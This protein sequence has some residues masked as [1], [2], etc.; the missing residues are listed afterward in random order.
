MTIDSWLSAANGDAS[1]LW[2]LSLMSRVAFP[3]SFVWGELA[4][5]AR[6]DTLAA[7]RYFASGPHRSDSILGNPG[8]EFIYGGGGLVNSWPATPG[9]NE[10]ATVRDSNVDTL[11]VGGQLDFATPAV[12]A[13]RELL[14]H[15]RNGHQVVLAGVGHTTSFWSYQPKAST[16]LL[17][18]FLDTGKVDRSLY[19]PAKVDFT[20]EISHTALG[21]GLA[22]TIIALPAIVLLSLLLMWR[23]SRKRGRIG[24][25]ASIALRSVFTLVLGLGGWFAGLLLVL[26]AFPAMALDNMALSVVAIGLPIG[27]GIYLAWLDRSRPGRTI[28]LSAAMAGSLVGAWLGFQA[29]NGLTAVITTII[30]AAIGANLPLIVLDTHDSST[31]EVVKAPQQV[32]TTALQ[33]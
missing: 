13:T 12:N 14:P 25:K 26:M 5:I 2:F 1:G 4:A 20:P 16:R 19:T 8:T 18:T 29:A 3:E 31:A 22:A 33:V 6:A 17:N 21:K 27:M 10:Y 30:G 23:R 9:E 11:L 32:P 7:K 28:G 15:L 24:R